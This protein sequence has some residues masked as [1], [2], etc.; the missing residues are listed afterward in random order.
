MA[1]IQFELLF[2]GMAYEKALDSQDSLYHYFT[3]F[4]IYYTTY[5]SPYGYPQQQTSRLIGVL[6]LDY[7]AGE[8]CHCR[9]SSLFF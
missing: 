9:L 3:T 6:E 1:V 4:T 8:G 2:A 5:T 7:R